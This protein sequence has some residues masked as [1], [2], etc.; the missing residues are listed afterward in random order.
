MNII[1]S[2]AIAACAFFVGIVAVNAFKDSFERYQQQYLASSIR[3]LSDMFLFI[4]RKKLGAIGLGLMMV[5]AAVGIFLGPVV[6]VLLAALGLLSPPILVRYY[7]Q[8]RLDDLEKQLPDTLTAIAGAM[9]SGLTFRQAVAEAGNLAPT[10]MSQE[11]GL[12]AREVQLGTPLDEALSRLAERTGSNEISLFVSSA[13]IAL[14][15]GGNLSEILEGLSTTLRERFRIEG[16][17]RTLTAQGKLQGII[18]GVMP[19]FVWLGFDFFRPDLTRPM[20]H[21]WFGFAMVGVIVVMELIGALLIRHIVR[22]EV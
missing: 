21:H 15:V 2:I 5:G 3:D 18:V 17:I 14:K 6:G 4:D 20:M 11:L 22:I 7:G 19:I 12:F 1:T 10:P 9:R 16:R 13:Q 8:Q